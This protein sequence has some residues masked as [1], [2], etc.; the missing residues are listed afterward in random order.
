MAVRAVPTLL[1]TAGVAHP[2]EN[3]RLALASLVHGTG[4]GVTA[5]S[6]LSVNAQGTPNMTVQVQPG[7]AWITGTSTTTQGSYHLYNDAALP[8]VAIAASNPTNPR[9]DIVVA[10]IRDTA[11]D[12]SGFSD[13][14]VVVVTGT[15]AV[16]PVAPATPASSLLLA[17]IAVGANVTT[18]TNANITDKRV[19]AASTG[20][21]SFYPITTGALGTAISLTVAAA[22]LAYSLAAINIFGT[23][24]ASGGGSLSANMPGGVATALGNVVIKLTDV[25]AGTSAIVLATFS[26]GTFSITGLVGGHAYSITATIV[27]CQV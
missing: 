22:L 5:A 3:I 19:M 12:G 20:Y 17:T 14:S 18:I 21:G 15:P 8:A 7:G 4:S 9:I 1:S 27:L 16:S 23:F 6:D 25:T 24:T 2:S 26:P 10:R 13:A 11:E